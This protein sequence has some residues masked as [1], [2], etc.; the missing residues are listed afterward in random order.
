VRPHPSSHP[1]SGFT[2]VELL[3]VLV[4]IITLIALASTAT[5]HLLERSRQTACTA[6]LRQIGVALQGYLIDHDGEL[7]PMRA[8]RSSIDEDVPVMDTVLLPYTNDTKIFRCPADHKKIWQESGSSYWWYETLTL[9]PS[10]EHNYRQVT[11]E[12]FF[13]ATSDL[14]KI[15]LVVDK[16]AF[17][18]TKHKI[19]ALYADGHAGPLLDPNPQSASP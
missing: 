17:H 15:P 9:K 12:S 14:S 1:H 8:M 7:P 3:V 13:L 10:G 16:E 6:N 5:N 11:L 2:L 19:N 4:I 18:K